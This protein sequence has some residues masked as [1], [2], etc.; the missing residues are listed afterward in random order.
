MI[1]NG[2]IS[3]ITGAGRG[4]GRAIAIE[5]ARKGSVVFVTSR[6]IDHARETADLILDNGDK[7]SFAKVDVTDKASIK[8]AVD[9]VV[10]LYDKID[11]FINNAG[12]STMG[13]A[14][15]LTEEE[16]DFNMNV[17]AK[18][19]F[20]GSQVAAMQMIKQGNGGKIINI[21]SQA[22]K[23]GIPF[24]A[25]YSASKFAVTG[26]TQAFALELAEHGIYVNAVCPGYVCTGM[27]TREIEWEAN[28]LGISKDQVRESYLE[29]IPLKRVETPDDVAKVVLFLAS[30]YSN[31]MTG[32]SINVTGGACMI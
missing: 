8:N 21:S 14:I 16:W 5:L 24:F 29:K 22:G 30:E 23:M 25:H 26:L 18:G 1:L 13:K 15:E 27:Q 7:A 32:Q 6:N 28:L 19:T 4:I 3:L 12:V 11:I 20:F 2:K 9:E 10:K 31:Y 17:N